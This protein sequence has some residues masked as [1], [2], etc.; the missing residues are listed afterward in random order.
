MKRST[1]YFV[2]IVS[3]LLI[4]AFINKPNDSIVKALL[5]YH[6]TYVQE[7]VFVQTD[8]SIYSQ[9]EDIW[10][11]VYLINGISH[12]PTALSSLIYVQLINPESEIIENRNIEIINGGGIADFKLS[13]DWAPGLYQ[14]RAFSNYQRNFAE[15]FLF[16]KY[17]TVVGN[18]GATSTTQIP[19]SVVLSDQ[20]KQIKVRMED[21]LV[22]FYPEGGDL[23][24]GIPSMIAIESTTKQGGRIALKG[25]IFDQQGNTVSVWNTLSNGYGITSFTPQPGFQYVAKVAGGNQ[26]KQFD[27]PIVLQSG[28]G[29]NIIRKKRQFE[30]TIRRS[31]SSRLQGG[32]LLAHARGIPS[33][34]YNINENKSAVKLRISRDELPAG[35]NHFTLFDANGTPQAERLVFVRPNNSAPISWELE[36]TQIANRQRVNLTIRTPYPDDTLNFANLNMRVLDAS[37]LPDDSLSN[38]LTYFLLESDLPGIPEIATSVLN[39]GKHQGEIVLD[40]IMLTQ[41]WRRFE[42]SNILNHKKPRVRHFI[43]KGFT[44]SGQVTRLKRLDKS[45]EGEVFINSLDG[46]FF[47]D[48]TKTNENG[49]F[50]FHNLVIQDSTTM[51]IQG[52]KSKGKKKE[53]EAYGPEGSRLVDIQLNRPE[54]P[55]INYNPVET[56]T[57][58]DSLILQDYKAEGMRMKI[59]RQAYDTM[60]I[61]FDEVIISATRIERDPIK[62][63]GLA[64]YNE[65][66]HRFILDSIPSAAY[67][68]D[69]FDI[70][71]ARV[72]GLQVLPGEDGFVP[73]VFFVTSISLS[74][75]NVPPLFVVDG[76]ITDIGHVMTIN[77]SD[78]YAVDVLKRGKAA[79]YGSRAYGGVI[80]IY[81]RTGTGVKDPVSKERY[82]IID[83]KH[84]GYYQARF[85]YSP[86]YDKPKPEDF[87]PD[88]RTTLYWHPL[89]LLRDKNVDVSFYTSDKSGTFDIYLEGITHDG[90]IIY[91]KKQLVVQ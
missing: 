24:A 32:Y 57:G 77:P 40:Y 66:T 91:Q 79:I 20:P 8:K 84:P 85:F 88:F 72:P 30:I 83:F 18:D 22:S 54:Y 6:Q 82:G 1:F 89:I 42:W 3:L 87:I 38:I 7:K 12:A 69:I 31:S 65:P 61:D 71:R 5:D 48:K 25:S 67:A 50:W 19:E 15:E 75:G 86:R 39:K 70:L 62:E 81:T 11:K 64:K 13:E 74:E 78:V 26:I 52:S 29:L 14:I 68:R 35:V 23:V 17:I 33:F 51:I 47:M 53:P 73:D 58:T 55:E 76:I 36:N 45:V 9:G 59:V 28:F 46:F 27:L 43:E 60:F 44:I 34:S 56:T 37:V 49:E 4:F 2:G 16:N 63:S 10:M 90:Q 80:A 21:I 41:G